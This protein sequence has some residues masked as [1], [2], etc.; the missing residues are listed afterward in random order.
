MARV[1]DTQ[2]YLDMVCQLLD[3]GKTQVPVTVSGHSMVPF[4]HEGDTVYLD[5]LERPAKQGDILLYRRPTGQYVLH[6]VW[7][8]TGKDLLLITGDAQQDLEPVRPQAVCALVTAALHK[9]R[10]CRPGDLRWWLYAHVWR[11]LRPCR[12]RLMSLREALRRKKR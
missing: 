4:L 10:L 2:S 11:W 7:K 3:Q 1:F 5:L 6:R 9:G 12:R 8:K